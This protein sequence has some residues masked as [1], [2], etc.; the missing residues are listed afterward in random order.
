M[1]LI[2]GLKLWTVGD[3][4]ILEDEINRDPWKSDYLGMIMSKHYPFLRPF[5]IFAK[6][7]FFAKPKFSGWGMS[8]VHENA[9]DSQYDEEVFNKAN[10]DIK[11]Q[12]QFTSTSIGVNTKNIDTLLWR[13]WIVSY[14]VRHAIEFAD[15]TEYNFVEC[16]VAEGITAF[17]A[18][19]QIITKKHLL[20]NFKMHLYDSWRGMREEDLFETELKNQ[21]QYEELDINI[22]R[23]NLAE[24]ND[25]LVYHKGYIPDSFRSEPK[26]P[27]SILYLHLDLFSRKPTLDA[28]E[29]F[30]PRVV[31]GGV[32]LFDTYAYGRHVNYKKIVDKFFHDKP[33]TLLKL[34][35]GQ[36]IYNKK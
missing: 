12:F 32:I 23:K 2:N 14:A 8:T 15:T 5:L 34:P 13:H 7:H 29:F 16:G 26:S 9:W 31:R 27:D 25:Y 6:N 3:L 11:K 30:Y 17:F 35:T 24:F 1:F 28:L 22:T 10:Q 18:L 21:S 36:A 20:K 4:V 19:R 33:G